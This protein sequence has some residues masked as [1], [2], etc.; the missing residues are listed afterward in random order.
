MSGGSQNTISQQTVP[1]WLQP[2]LSSELTSGNSLVQ[3]GGPQYYPGQQVAPLTSMQNEGI[4]GVQNQASQPNAATAA[5]QQ[6]QTIESGAYLNPNTNPYLAGTLNTANQGVQNQISSEFGSAGR[7]VVGSAP[8]QSS[9]MNQLANQI[10]GGAYQSGMNN[11]V[12]GQALA[13]QLDAATYLP[14]SELLQTGAGV[15]GQN[16]SNINANMN[17]YNYTQQLPENMLSWYSGLLSQNG[18]PFG[19]SSTSASGSNNSA[20]TDIGAGVAGASALSSLAGLFG[21]GEGLGDLFALGM[22]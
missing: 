10:Y 18:A 5:D 13:P 12:Q 1:S 21:S 6:N 22:A 19:G 8:V 9:A 14:S 11:I 17:A 20:M 7:N 3:G 15:Q 16:Q 2:Y 4:A